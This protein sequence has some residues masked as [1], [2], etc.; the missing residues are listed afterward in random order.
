MNATQDFRAKVESGSSASRASC[1]R[2]FHRFWLLVGLAGSFLLPRIQPISAA[3]SLTSPER[4]PL[5]PDQAPIGD[6][7]SETA[8]AFITV[9][10][11]AVTNGAAVVICPGGGYG[12]LVT[13]PEGSGIA[14]WLNE[15]GVTGIVLEYRLPHG[16]PFV[17]LLDAQRAIRTV[18][19]RAQEWGCD[20]ARVGIIG[21]SAGGHLAATAATHFDPGDARATDAIE[22]IGSRPDFAILI[23]PVITMGEKTHQGSKANLLGPDPTPEIVGQFSN[24]LQVTGQ[25]PPTFLAHALDD[26]VVTVE[27]SQI[28]YQALQT[29]QVRTRLL[30]LP[31]G[32]H[33][34]NGY[35]G[36][37]WDTWQTESLQ[38]LAALKMIPRQATPGGAR[39]FA[40][41]SFP[42]FQTLAAG[43]QQ[44]RLLPGQSGFVFTLYGAPGELDKVEQLVEVMGREHLGNGFDP[45]PSPRPDSTALVHY[46]TKL[47]WPVVFYSGGEMQI[48]GGRSVFGH[49]METAL[50]PMDRAGVFNAYQLGEWG[51]Y[52][53]NLAPNESWWHDVYGKDFDAYKHLMKPNGLAGYDRR[54]ATRRECYEVVKDYFMSRKHDLLDRVISVTGHSHYEAYVGEWG[55][56][57]IG[58]EV[59]E[60]IAFTQSKLAFARGASR[61]WRTPWSVQV[62]PW[63]SGACTTSGPLRTEGHDARGL[64]A[65][66][67]LSFYER[68]WLHG[69]FAGAAMVTPENSI[70][71]FFEKPE[72]PW[73][74]TSHGRKAAEVFQFMQG[75][76]RGIPYTPVAVVLDHLAGYNAYMDKPWGILDPT[77]GD[78]EIR[79]LFDHQLFPGSD[80]IHAKPDPM[81]PEVS[82]LRP[83]PFGEIFDVLLT[84]VPPGV[85]PTY[86]VILLAGDIEFD[87]AFL[88]EL[89]N[90]LRHG[91][92]L[93][94]SARQRESLG[95]DF[96]RLAAEG[97]VEVLESWTNPATARPTAISNDRLGRLVK[98]LLPF[99]VAGDAIQYE[100]NR[101]PNGWVVELVNNRGVVK[102]PSQPATTDSTAT[103]R[104]RLQPKVSV[105]S[106]NEWRS[107]RKQLRGEPIEIEV[108]PG[109]VEFVEFLEPTK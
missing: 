75:H 7:Q 70:A 78:R 8:N 1:G 81:K 4:I 100:I 65:G 40:E 55:A 52:F 30:E 47:G 19:A 38:W 11:P 46:L 62:S 23:Y 83:T 90:A 85:L 98:E 18:R 39:S 66:H 2:I 93:L 89:E 57:C 49:E 97:E 99:E 60:N 45:G 71:I 87:R 5:W 36:P 73:N 63:F 69:W 67:S 80:H 109:A 91:S 22:R 95:A 16:R 15:H 3:E 58:L 48:R 107:G 32:G 53:H 21:F 43:A 34:L 28:F 74:L 50:A 105:R 13:G 29:H 72:A 14:R 37:S 59:G 92:R 24:E 64:D 10:H 76:D 26:T 88:G 20:P 106:V 31:S 33:G 44:V 35:K 56:R 27:N 6:G 104:I 101:T 17:P 41:I 84:S 102:K 103:A 42:G 79:D 12:G 82:Y 9:F 108:G 77:P 51:Y 96:A 25:T 68:M 61:Q 54:P 94:M 86:P